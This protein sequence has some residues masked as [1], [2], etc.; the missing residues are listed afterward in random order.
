MT[1]TEGG[2]VQ[3]EL[4]FLGTGSALPSA[5][6]NHTCIALRLDGV[7][8][9]FDVGEGSQ[10]QLMKSNNIRI[11]KIE[12]IFVTHLHGDHVFGLPGLMCTMTNAVGGGGGKESEAP[13]ADEKL[14]SSTSSSTSKLPPIQI[15][16]PAGTRKYIRNSLKSS[17]SRLGLDYQVH[18][19]LMIND[20][21]TIDDDANNRHPNELLGSDL[22][23]D[24]ATHTWRVFEDERCT[25]VASPL[26]HTVPSIGFVVTERPA[27]GKLNIDLA[28]PI[29]EKH[30]D[31]IARE[32][33][34]KNPM[35]LL[36]KVK[37]GNTIALPDGT[38]IIS[39]SDVVGA[40][41]PG[42]KVVV[43]GDTSDNSL[44]QPHCVDADVVVHE[45][46]NACLKSDA[47]RTT[48]EEVEKT[49]RDHGHSTP[50][51]AG[52]FAKSCNAKGLILTHF[53]QRYKGDSEEASLSVMREIRDLAI[54]EFGC[55]NVVTAYDF[56][57]HDIKRKQ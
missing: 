38:V 57:V 19:L 10:H 3:M 56:Y 40:P 35:S 29:L 17:Y 44:I 52:A 15:Y 46:T 48:E 2:V 39:P 13:E 33:K 7:F 14:A 5:T 16:G 8:W 21:Q 1:T 9:L 4:T 23:L 31:A 51:M 30:K 55:D 25:V 11:G 54:R 49:T 45:A 24:E 42:R 37:A 20:E 27:P 12:K 53:S 18:E 47:A 6:R 28:K 41:R 26:T 43:L 36:A 34:I 50:Q 32:L 22:L